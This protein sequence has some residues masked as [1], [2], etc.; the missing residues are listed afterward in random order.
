MNAN[1]ER[2]DEVTYQAVEAGQVL[3][4]MESAKNRMNIMILDA[5]RNNPFSRSWRSTGDKGLAQLNAPT[6]S[7]IAFATAPGREAA[8]GAK[9][10]G[11]YTEALLAQLREPGMELE[12]VFKRTREKVIAA[13]HGQQTPWESNSTVGD[14]FFVPAQKPVGSMEPVSQSGLVHGALGAPPEAI[15]LLGGLQVIVNAPGTRVYVDGE[16]RGEASP[17]HALNLPDLPVG[18]VLVKVEAPGYLPKEQPFS[19]Q[20]SQWVQARL[21]LTRNVGANAPAALPAV[22]TKPAKVAPVPATIDAV[23]P[24][25]TISAGTSPLAPFQNRLGMNFVSIPAGSFTMGD[26]AGVGDEKPEHLVQISRPFALQTTPVTVKQWKAFVDATG[27]TTTAE[28]DGKVMIRGQSGW[29]YWFPK[30][31]LSW[32]DPGFDQQ[33]DHPVVCI[34]WD[35]AQAFLH[36]LNQEDPERGYRL[37]TEAE[38]EYACRAGTKEPRYGDVDKIAW[39]WTKPRTY[40]VGKKAPNSWGLFDMLGNAAQWCQDWYGGKYYQAKPTIDPQGPALGDL[41]VVRGGGWYLPSSKVR[42]GYRNRTETYYF[43]NDV[44]FR[45]AMNLP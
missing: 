37:P 22:I 45:I 42:S 11:L 23:K 18:E 43:L 19:V 6:G 33:E 31:G 4:K 28:A 36:W 21:V 8:D 5:C 44:G 10:H 26:N 16:L 17:T 2:E 13:S 1:L 7:F 34:S 40:P 24:G 12:K 27:Y 15:G 3:D 35:D 38:W 32:R 14:F 25:P 30:R 41:R 29:T 20:E 9:E 39:Y